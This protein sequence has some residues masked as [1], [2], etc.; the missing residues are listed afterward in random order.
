MQFFF[1]KLQTAHMAV[2]MFWNKAMVFQL[3]QVLAILLLSLQIF[4]PRR[5]I[6]IETVWETIQFLR[7]L[8]KCYKYPLHPSRNQFIKACYYVFFLPGQGGDSL[9][10]F[11]VVVSN[12]FVHPYLVKMNPF[13]L[14]HIFSDGLVK[15]HQPVSENCWNQLIE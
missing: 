9:L 8:V 2:R 12:I 7:W 14:A 13:W 6:I 3:W 5:L 10:I 11:Q 15:N 1:F 4:L